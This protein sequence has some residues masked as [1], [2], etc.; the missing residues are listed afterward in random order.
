MKIDRGEWGSFVVRSLA[1]IAVVSFVF[2]AVM[3][4]LVT[5]TWLQ[6]KLNDPLANPAVNAIYE[7]LRSE[8]ED[9]NLKAE[10]RALDLLAR[11]AYF[12]NRG[13]V[14]MGGI[15]VLA[16]TA[17]GAL[18]LAARELVRKKL[19]ASPKGRPVPEPEPTRLRARRAVVI[20]GAALLAGSLVIAFIVMPG[21]PGL[22]ADRAAAGPEVSAPPVSADPALADAVA[23]RSWPGFRGPSGRG[24]AGRGDW[25]T[26]WDGT[27][28]VGIRWKKKLGLPGTN[29]PVVVGGTVFLTGANKS[30]G[31][32]LG[33]SAA[34]GAPL[35]T[36]RIDFGPATAKIKLD[37]QN[38]GYAAPTVAADQDRLV[39][40]F[41]GGD[42]VC[43]DHAGKILW[44]K[45]LGTP[46]M[47][48]GFASSPLLS[49]GT[50]F[51]Q[52][53]HNGGARLIALDPTSGAVRW[54]K[55]RDV[56]SSW[57]S[58]TTAVVKGRPAIVLLS[59]PFTAA[60]DAAT[61]QELWSV[62]LLTGEIG[63]SPTFADGV[64]FAGNDPGILAALN[65][66]D[67]KE[68]WEY[69]DDLPNVSSPVVSQGLLFMA[70]S[71]GVVTCLDAKTGA[72]AW[73]QDFTDGFYASPVVAGNTVYLLDREGVTHLVAATR[74]YAHANANTLGEP[75]DATPAFAE[76]RMYIR[77]KRNL[78][79][80][81][82]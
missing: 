31:E 30:R 68:L 55:K 25:P 3:G 49:G 35:F 24:V 18:A 53:D 57:A 77:G 54:E 56:F 81:G 26:A 66:D 37:A 9:E 11:R 60:Y 32:V 61:G 10:V 40:L 7:R 78:Y 59:N 79:C 72:L 36:T 12:T 28:G 69:A 4:V 38:V 42:L 6:L 16:G 48:Y 73:R 21:E 34:D 23:A 45:N 67:G 15:L 19:P 47:N 46:E 43:L 8:P 62:E 51:I 22:G 39:A 63:A 20:G 1:G 44:K 50:L 58:P 29:S 13:Q 64:V 71:A 14:M 80:I 65:A 52:Y 2:A 17:A 70:S 74:T 75:A 76:G 27:S 82:K 33:F 5:A 41:A